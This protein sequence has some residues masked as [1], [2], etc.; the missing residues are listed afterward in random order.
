MFMLG[1]PNTGNNCWL[2]A[3]LQALCGIDQFVNNLETIS[4]ASINDM[5]IVELAKTVR[6]MESN[7]RISSLNK[8]LMLCTSNFR[9]HMAQQQ[10]ASEFATLLLNHM[11]DKLERTRNLQLLND[12]KA[13]FEFKIS[14][15][16]QCNYM[17]HAMRIVD[18]RFFVIP[19][20]FEEWGSVWDF[21]VFRI[22]LP[23]KQLQI[24][25]QRVKQTTMFKNVH[26]LNVHHAKEELA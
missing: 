11:C 17:R 16:N 12:F 7:Q 21:G 14:Y 22:I 2:N 25:P 8:L 1:L 3:T 24:A 4:S 15:K 19:I 23:K 10:D 6:N 5:L 13:R 26:P 18:Q 9:F 20:A